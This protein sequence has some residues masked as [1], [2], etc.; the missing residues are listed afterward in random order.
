MPDEFRNPEDRYRYV[1]GR[2]HG[3]M[4]PSMG[5][6]KWFW[7]VIAV[8]VIGAVMLRMF[9]SSEESESS[10]VNVVS[11]P[12][13]IAFFSNRDGDDEIY[14]MNADGSG[15]ERLTDDEHEDDNPAWSPDGGMM[16][17]PP[18]VFPLGER[19]G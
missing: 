17:G 18:F 3:S 9:G 10:S 12:T 6:L 8:V 11:T 15:V 19:E 1:Q 13:S 4:Y 5:E 14:V 7:L 2:A 16:F